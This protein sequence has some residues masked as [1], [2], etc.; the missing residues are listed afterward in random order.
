MDYICCHICGNI[1]VREELKDLISQRKSIIY[2][3]LL[4]VDRSEPNIKSIKEKG[5]KLKIINNQILFIENV[6]EFTK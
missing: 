5:E 6:M 2:F 1:L 3:L 4:E